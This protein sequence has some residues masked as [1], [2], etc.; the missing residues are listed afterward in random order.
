MATL[1]QWAERLGVSPRLIKID[2][3]GA[4]VLALRGAERLMAGA[5]GPRPTFLVAVHPHVLAEYGCPP[6]GIDELVRARGYRAVT[7]GG[8][9]ARPT[10]FAEYVLE[11]APEGRPS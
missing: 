11:P 6:D 8:A 2:V 3:E 4:E 10:A 5:F 1:D 7:V 9:P